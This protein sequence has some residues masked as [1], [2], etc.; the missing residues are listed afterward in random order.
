MIIKA[1][2]DGHA[3]DKGYV[4]QVHKELFERNKPVLG[5]CT[6]LRCFMIIGPYYLQYEMDHQIIGFDKGK[7]LVGR[8]VQWV[9]VYDSFQEYEAARIMTL[10][11][12]PT[13][14][15]TGYFQNN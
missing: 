11:T 10:G 12:Q 1:I 13:D 6:T 2:Q 3:K 4:A 8:S 15:V 9:I 5:L 14:K 7:P